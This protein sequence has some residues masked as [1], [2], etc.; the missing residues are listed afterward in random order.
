MKGGEGKGR[1]AGSDLGGAADKVLSSG[2]KVAAEP[3]GATALFGLEGCL[4]LVLQTETVSGLQV[5]EMQGGR[6]GIIVR[7]MSV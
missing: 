4:R 1:S 7:V 3:S 6:G 2:T 5:V